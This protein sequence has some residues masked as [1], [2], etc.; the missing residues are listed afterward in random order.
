MFTQDHTHTR[1]ISR[2]NPKLQ[3]LTDGSRGRVSPGLSSRIHPRVDRDVTKTRWNNMHKQDARRTEGRSP[4]RDATVADCVACSREFGRRL[5]EDLGVPVFLYGFAS[6]RDYRKTMPQIRAGEYEGLGEKLK[7]P[8]WAP[9]YGPASLVPRW[10][11]TVTGCR[12][13]LIA[14][15]INVLATKEQAHRIALNL[16]EGGRGKEQPGRLKSCQAI[17]WWLEEENL[18]QISINLTDTDVTPIHVAYEEVC[19]FSVFVF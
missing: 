3:A 13:F 8:E 17:G 15:N 14:Y 5:A 11:A 6:D 9:D 19:D 7:K 16:R 2:R 18:A 4:V 10:G 1:D 12:K